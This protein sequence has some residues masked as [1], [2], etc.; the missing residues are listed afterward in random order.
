M[1]VEA[2]KCFWPCENSLRSADHRRVEAGGGA[3]PSD[4][5]RDLRW[6]VEKFMKRHPDMLDF[7][8][9][10]AVVVAESSPFII[11]RH[12][13]KHD[14]CAGVWRRRRDVMERGSTVLITLVD[15]AN[16]PSIHCESATVAGRTPSW[17]SWMVWSLQM[18]RT[19]HCSC[20]K[21]TFSF[22]HDAHGGCLRTRLL[23]L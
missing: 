9:F 23:K 19:S 10:M 18:V 1:G 21:E 14:T 11:G 3:R 22:L 2:V 15:H 6:Y 8:R 20:S 7:R 13:V 4:V 16:L 12:R 17:G 5:V